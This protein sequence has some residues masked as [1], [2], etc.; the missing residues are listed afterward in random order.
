[1]FACFYRMYFMLKCIFK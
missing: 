1:M